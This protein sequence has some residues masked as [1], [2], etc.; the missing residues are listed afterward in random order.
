[1]TIIKSLLAATGVVAQ[2]VG[3]ASLGFMMFDLA[4]SADVLVQQ[5]AGNDATLQ[6]LIVETV[7]SYGPYFG[8]GVVGA[9]VCWL[10]ILKGKYRAEWFLRTS[11]VLAWAW[12]P[13]IPVGTVLGALVLSARA[14]AV[15][16]RKVH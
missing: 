8:V 13:L 9:I 10:L 6:R 14:A 5:A 7:Y 12:M 2:I 11:R 1:M 4:L 15:E 16:S 3:F